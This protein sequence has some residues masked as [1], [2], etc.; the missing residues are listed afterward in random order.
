MLQNERGKLSITYGGSC[1]WGLHWWLCHKKWFQHLCLGS[2]PLGSNCRTLQNDTESCKGKGRQNLPLHVDNK[3]SLRELQGEHH[4]SWAHITHHLTPLP[5]Y[6]S[7]TRPR[8]GLAPHPDPP[9]VTHSVA[10]SRSQ[11]SGNR[12]RAA[13]NTSRC[14]GET[15]TQQHTGR[16]RAVAPT[17]RARCRPGS[18]WAAGWADAGCPPP[19]PRPGP[20]RSAG[21]RPA[22]GRSTAEEAEGEANRAAGRGLVAA[23]LGALTRWQATE[24]A[25]KRRPCAGSS[26]RTSRRAWSILSGGGGPAAAAPPRD[27]VPPGASNSAPSAAATAAASAAAIVPPRSALGRF[28]SGSA[29]GAAAPSWRSRASGRAAFGAWPSAASRR[30]VPRAA[31]LGSAGRRL[32][33]LPWNSPL[34]PC[35][36]EGAVVPVSLAG[37]MEK[38]AHFVKRDFPPREAPS[39][40]LL[41]LVVAVLLLNAL[42]YLY[43]GNLH[44]SSGRADAEPS[45]CPY[46][47]F[48]LGPVKNC[49]PWLSCEAINREVRKLKC[50]GEGAVKKVSL[51]I[52]SSLRWIS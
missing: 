10:N 24:R 33:G 9:T 8:H 19:P 32:C 30:H 1:W 6:A 42:L 45:L 48:K 49:S 39:L 38:K 37:E 50:V 20:R 44:G 7:E 12:W 34:E 18:R 3:A 23:R 26:L 22:A 46:G 25:A 11:R 17:C 13:T 29:L 4:P 28:R 2:L 14:A 35:A 31:R 16:A 52:L 41:L 15:K 5:P 36:A 47:S 27:C 43:L 21:R 40:L 51:V